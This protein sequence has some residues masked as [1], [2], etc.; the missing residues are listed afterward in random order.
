MNYIQAIIL[1]IIEG[2]TEFL[3]VSS[4]GHLIIGSALLGIDSKDQFVQLF[5]VAIQLGTI[6][7][8]IV[9]YFK[10]FLKSLN[11]YYK[12][13]VAFLPAVVFGLLLD[14]QIEH[15]LGSI[16]TVAIS[17]LI[18]G[19]VLLFIDNVFKNPQE[20]N[21]DRIK[22]KNAFV[23]GIWQCLAMIP[24]VSRSAA[25]I[26]GGMQQKL[27]KKAA[28][29]FS[30]FLAVPTMF[31]A[32][33]KKLYDFY[34]QGYHVSAHQWGLLGVGNVVGFVVAI[35]AIKAFINYVSKNG[36]QAFGV[37]RII[38]GIIILAFIFSGHS[39]QMM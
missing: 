34:K 7:S 23:I 36:F 27:T 3:P 32:T 12:L 31:G 13:F 24:G 39:L 33:A 6:L 38:V 8:V 22:Y 4:T 18:G 5:I 17:L 37:Y 2:L 16:E 21:A 9:L 28:A 14:K 25:S 19:I 15:F 11:F 1:G 20:D 35:I 10:R 26:I 30:F 29:E